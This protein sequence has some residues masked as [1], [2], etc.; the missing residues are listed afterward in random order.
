MSFGGKPLEPPVKSLKQPSQE[1]FPVVQESESKQQTT[2]KQLFVPN[3]D[4]TREG[5]GLPRSPSNNNIAKVPSPR[6][7]NPLVKSSSNNDEFSGRKQTLFR[8]SSST[9][10]STTS[11]DKITAGA[12]SSKPLSPRV[13]YLLLLITNKF[14]KEP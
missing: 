8:S 7:P 5:L 11:V 10:M 3:N 14:F 12:M 13:I 9:A 6:P 4:K 2:N 1:E